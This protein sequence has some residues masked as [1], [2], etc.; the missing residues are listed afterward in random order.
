L[1]DNHPLPASAEEAGYV[2]YAEKVDGNKI[3][4][5]S[6]SFNDHFSQATLFWNSLSDVEKQHLIDAA[7]FELG[8]VESMEVR[9]RVI[10]LFANIDPELAEKA[11]NGIGVKVSYQKIPQKKASRKKMRGSV[12]PTPERSE[13]LSMRNTRKDT[14][15]SRRIAVLV[16]EGVDLKHLMK[17]KEALEQEG[18]H[19]EIV[20]KFI[21]NLGKVGRQDVMVDKNYVTTRSIMYDAIFIP[22]GRESIDTL[23]MHGDALHFVTEAFKH[24]KAIAATAEGVDLLM[25]ANLNGIN[26]SDGDLASDKGVI[27]DR[28]LSN[29]ST[30]IKEF[31]RAIAAHRHWEREAIKDSI[32][33]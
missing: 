29:D 21:G 9:E 25:K 6:D 27:T 15:R 16:G 8:K 24:C 28:D 26:L 14:I 22:G 2:H 18:A 10:G 11:A 3:R 13:A 12:L 7:H 32:P 4:A 31:M 23:T 33:A 1:R 17:V 5:R 30:F 19:V 20:S